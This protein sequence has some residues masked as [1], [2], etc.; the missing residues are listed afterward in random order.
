MGVGG[1]PQNWEAGEWGPPWG[2]AWRRPRGWNRGSQPESV[3]ADAFKF[4]GVLA[5]F[6]VLDPG[7]T[8]PL[9]RVR[10]RGPGPIR[11]LGVHEKVF[12]S[13]KIRK[14]KKI[15]PALYSS[16][17]QGSHKMSFLL[18]FLMEEKVQENRNVGS[19]CQPGAAQKLFS[20]CHLLDAENG[21]W[22]VPGKSLMSKYIH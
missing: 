16:L 3:F 15:Q 7:W 21:R 8:Q 19:P 20:K 17:Y 6:G 22:E 11:V 4:A 10:I 9:S 5:I 1:S 18:F 12:I 2:G 14:K 13:F